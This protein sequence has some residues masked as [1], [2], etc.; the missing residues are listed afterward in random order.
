MVASGGKMLHFLGEPKGTVS[1]CVRGLIQMKLKY[2]KLNGSDKNEK[3]K[4]TTPGIPTWSP[5]V[6]LTRPYNA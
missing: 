3:I 5:T 6:V 4:R 2:L 1:L